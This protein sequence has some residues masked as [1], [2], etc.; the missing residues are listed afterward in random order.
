MAAKRQP[1][2]NGKRTKD[3]L[4]AG[5]SDAMQDYLREIYKLQSES[6]RVKT[7]TLAER[8]GVA[9]PSATAMVKKLAGL[10]LV[11]HEL[12]RGARLTRT[13]ERTALEVIRHHRLLELYLAETFE[14]GLDAV[15]AE[16]DR[17]EHALS[18]TLE[19]RID[20]ALGSPRQDP[21]GDPI[22]DARL[23]IAEPKAQPLSQLGPGDEATVLRVPDRDGEL[24][25][26]LA[27]LSLIPGQRVVCVAAEPLRGP[28]TVRTA[29]RET[30]ISREL[31][32]QIRVSI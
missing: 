22:P 7:S 31:A 29:G 28:V 3:T 9:A 2:A 20:E 6:G 11:E 13:G 16:A 25:R 30:A 5:L 14:L 21:H 27:T 8:M 24:L 26:Y 19:R 10:G 12:Y 4:L 32:D 1:H 23:R 15:H 17:L 18:E